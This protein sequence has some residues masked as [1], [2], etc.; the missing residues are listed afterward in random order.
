MSERVHSIETLRSEF[1][2]LLGEYMQHLEPT[3][4]TD[5]VAVRFEATGPDLTVFIDLPASGKPYMQITLAQ[6]GEGGKPV[7]PPRGPSL[8]GLRS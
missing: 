5:V 8:F 7:E 6:Q 2:A 3:A 4:K 1:A